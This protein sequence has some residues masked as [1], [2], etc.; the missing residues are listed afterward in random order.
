M[1]G[2]LGFVL[3]FVLGLLGLVL[4]LF[5]LLRLGW[6]SAVVSVEVGI[7]WG[8]TEGLMLRFLGLVL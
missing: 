5:P 6:L 7:L 3:G 2:L 1:L 8:D 4:R